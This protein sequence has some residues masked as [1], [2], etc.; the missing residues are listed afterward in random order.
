MLARFKSE[1]PTIS[2]AEIKK[3][4]DKWDRYSSTFDTSYKDITK[5]T[6]KQV[7]QLIDD[8]ETRSK[9]K[10]KS[11]DSQPS[12]KDDTIY[13]QNNLL[14]LLG[15]LKEKCIQYGKGYN[16]C[17]SRTD[18][19]NMYYQ[20]RTGSSEPVF[21]FV[22]D[23]ER[24]KTDPWHA[25]VIHV[26]KNGTYRVTDTHNQKDALMTWGEIEQKAPRLRGLQSLFKYVPMSDDEKKYSVKVTDKVYA[27]Y[28]LKEK[29]MYITFGHTLTP[30]QQQSTPD[31]LI[32]VYAKRHTDAITKQTYDRLRPGDQRKIYNDILKTTPGKIA[33][34]AI[35]LNSGRLPKEYEDRI[36]E[37]VPAGFKYAARIIKDRWPELEERILNSPASYKV[38]V[39]YAQQMIKGRWPE[40]EKKMIKLTKNKWF[41][42]ALYFYMQDLNIND[43][44][45]EFEKRILD[46]IL[47]APDRAELDDSPSNTNV[48]RIS[49]IQAGILYTRDIVKG[50][51]L[52]FERLLKDVKYNDLKDYYANLFKIDPAQIGEKQRPG[53]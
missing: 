27:G 17:I 31:E 49:A 6:L 24:P 44:I 11:F 45:P 40:A 4:L 36:L 28:S 29:Y 43:R 5:L 14:I 9:I 30:K 13:D 19:N 34:F 52:E 25:V 21:Y 3:Y 2:D 47:I 15:D 16:W 39:Q 7:M 23:R 8:A 18:A 42:K 26:T 12:S 32:G 1:T 46:D 35:M 51:W 10:G 20:Y 37:S 41:P 53:P 22:F 50:R 48:R 38:I 33:N